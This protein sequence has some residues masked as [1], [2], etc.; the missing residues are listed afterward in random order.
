MLLA[1]ALS[2]CG[3]DVYTRAN[4]TDTQYIAD[5]NACFAYG[6][7]QPPAVLGGGPDDHAYETNV[8]KVRQT[9][10]HCMIARG[11]TLKPKWP[12]GPYGDSPTAGP[13]PAK[14]PL[15]LRQ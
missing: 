8:A 1:A 11:Y 10:R 3:H 13:D 4:T 2:G 12:F 9:I 7:G 5:E 15:G 6:E 14:T